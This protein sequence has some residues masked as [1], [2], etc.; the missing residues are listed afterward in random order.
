MNQIN[1]DKDKF[2]GYISEEGEGVWISAI[3]AKNIG[4]GDFSALIKELKANYKW[5]KI[6]TPSKMMFERATHLGFKLKGEYFGEPFN[7]YGKI[8]YWENG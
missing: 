6:P 3:K 4:K 2:E 8:M 7:E 5:I 1:L